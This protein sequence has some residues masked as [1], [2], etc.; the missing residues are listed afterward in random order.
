MII[1]EM[2][3][4][5]EFL[6]GRKITAQLRRISFFEFLPPFFTNIR[7]EVSKMKKII[8]QDM[9]FKV[10]FNNKISS[11][12]DLN[13]QEAETCAALAIRNALPNNKL[14]HYRT[15]S[16]SEVDFILKVKD[17]YIPIEVKFR[18]KVQTPIVLKNFIK[19][20][21][22]IKPVVITKHSLA[23]TSNARFI[24]LPLVE[25]FFNKTDTNNINHAF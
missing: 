10:A 6:T 17:K 1:R 21:D 8:L 12:D 23:E 25:C 7:K 2:T 15:I 9:G 24:P 14:Y 3:K 5:S 16:K 22:C 20:Y 13:R 19:K 4:N 18:N 11:F